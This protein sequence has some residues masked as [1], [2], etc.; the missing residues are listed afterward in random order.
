MFRI[1]CLAFAV[2]LTG[3]AAGASPREASG[4]IPGDPSGPLACQ[5]KTY[6]LAR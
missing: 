3:C 5:A 6:T 1:A 4:C 2:A